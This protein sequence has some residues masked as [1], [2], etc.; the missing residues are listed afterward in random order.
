MR[1]LPEIS[2]IPAKCLEAIHD[3]SVEDFEGVEDFRVT[4]TV[5][6][7]DGQ[8]RIEFELE[9]PT[10]FW[11]V[12]VEDDLFRANADEFQKHFINIESENGVTKMEVCQRG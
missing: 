2:R 8:L 4:S 9:L 10:F 7:G 3:F 11:A 12:E 1:E 6:T 5:A